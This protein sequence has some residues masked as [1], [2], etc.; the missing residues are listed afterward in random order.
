MTAPGL[1]ES[2]RGG[3]RSARLRRSSCCLEGL[4]ARIPLNVP[5]ERDVTWTELRSVVPAI[6]ARCYRPS[7]PVFLLGIPCEVPSNFALLKG[8]VVALDSAVHSPGGLIALAR[9]V[10][11]VRFRWL[12]TSAA[13]RELLR[14]CEG[15]EWAAAPADVALSVS[16]KAFRLRRSMPLWRRL[17]GELARG[18]RWDDICAEARRRPVLPRLARMELRRR[19][20]AVN[21]ERILT[22]E[23]IALARCHARNSGRELARN[24][25]LPL[26]SCSTGRFMERTSAARH[27]SEQLVTPCHVAPA[28]LAEAIE[29]GIAP[30][31]DGDYSN[32]RNAFSPA[33][34]ERLHGAFENWA[35]FTELER[36]AC[37]HDRARFW[38]FISAKGSIG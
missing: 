38:R 25:L 28:E 15:V 14:V 27:L 2:I 31:A 26:V 37:E 23:L 17:L 6:L 35:V 4:I 33:T 19:G 36:F 24:W 12:I 32:F 3:L 9:A 1:L 8:L 29:R 22:A 16:Q 20:A 18:E 30:L 34:W 21:R 13:R 10:C 11:S 7:L 5:C